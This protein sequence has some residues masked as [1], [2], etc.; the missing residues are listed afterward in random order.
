[1]IRMIRRYWWHTR[2]SL[3]YKSVFYKKNKEQLLDDILETT[4]YVIKGVLIGIM[5]NII[6]IPMLQAPILE[7]H[8]NNCTTHFSIVNA[9]HTD[10]SEHQCNT[11]YFIINTIKQHIQVI[12]N[13]S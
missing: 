2:M 13:K 6:I 8:F 9:I 12:N 4:L 1:M 7:Q 5:I 3:Q 11:P 10:I